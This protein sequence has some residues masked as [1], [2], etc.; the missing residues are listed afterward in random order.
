MSAK[1]KKQQQQQLHY[2]VNGLFTFLLA[3]KMQNL[4]YIFIV[5]YIG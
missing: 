3:F 2:F 4:L 1:K 5:K